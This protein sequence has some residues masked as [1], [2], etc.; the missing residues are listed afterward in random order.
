MLMAQKPLPY[1]DLDRYLWHPS[2]GWEF[3]LLC[4]LMPFKCKDSSVTE[5]SAPNFV[6]SVFRASKSISFFDF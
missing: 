6:S 2:I 4:E 3:P 5:I 1:D